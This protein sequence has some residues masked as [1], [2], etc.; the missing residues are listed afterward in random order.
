M[1]NT[2]MSNL[3]GSYGMDISPMGPMENHMSPY[4][5]GM[6][7]SFMTPPSGP[8]S[9]S[10]PP[11]PSQMQNQSQGSGSVMYASSNP[12]STHFGPPYGPNNQQIPPFGGAASGNA[13]FQNTGNQSTFGYSSSMS[14]G[15]PTTSSSFMSHPPQGDEG[16]LQSQTGMPFYPPQNTSPSYSMSV[17]SGHDF[18]SQSQHQQLPMSS[19]SSS[20]SSLTSAAPVLQDSGLMNLDRSIPSPI[21]SPRHVTDTPDSNKSFMD[22][23]N[24]RPGNTQSNAPQGF[25]S[26]SQNMS[27]PSSGYSFPGYDSTNSSSM[28]G[29]SGGFG[30]NPTASLSPALSSH[31]MASD[32]GMEGSAFRAHQGS[33]AISMPAKPQP[34]RLD[35]G[36]IGSGGSS[37][38]FNYNSGMS[39]FSS[40]S[41]L[42]PNPGAGYGSS[43]TFGSY[44]SGYTGG[45]LP[46]S[47]STMMPSPQ[48][49]MG[50]PQT[51]LG[52]PSMSSI[53]MGAVPPAHPS[54]GGTMWPM[55]PPPPMMGGGYSYPT[56][57]SS[58]MGFSS[59]LDGQG[60]NH[61]GSSSG[62]N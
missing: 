25:G 10:L 8:F 19:S 30:M 6:H 5:V 4:M 41:A 39:A 29:N 46:F 18:P 61:L 60:F 17:T 24:S 48:N 38:G 36:G 35:K 12:S 53:M 49:M 50:Y 21:P 9:Q 7:Q 1:N 52:Y 54:M 3:V 33:S 27:G 11:P 58:S 23:S 34:F 51:A 26:G 57:P 31:S 13:M 45:P 43:S 56:H 62:E 22:L 40:P 20:T 59:G 47:S 42:A 14:F 32:L 15:A 37:A 16:F 55:M 28:A 44:G 2:Y